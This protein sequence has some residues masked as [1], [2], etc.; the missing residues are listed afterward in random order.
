MD[1]LKPTMKVSKKHSEKHSAA[2]E[3]KHTSQAA[4]RGR[5]G[6]APHVPPPAAAPPTD[7]YRVAGSDHLWAATP[8]RISPRPPKAEAFEARGT[9]PPV[10]ARGRFF[11]LDRRRPAHRYEVAQYTFYD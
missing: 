8:K 5:T 3:K 6:E 1:V 10:P 9:R 11:G 4:P 2:K 7:P